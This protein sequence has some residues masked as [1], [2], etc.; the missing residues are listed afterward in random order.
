VSGPATNSAGTP[1]QGWKEFFQRTLDLPPPEHT[2]DFL[3]LITE[4]GS[5][6]D[7]GCG[8]GRFAVAFYRDR[9]D[10]TID[11]IDAHLDQAP[12]LTEDTAWL[13][14]RMQQKFKDFRAHEE[15]D[16]IWAWN[17]LFFTPPQHQQDIFH[18]LS[19]ALKPKGSLVF[20]FVEPCEG[21]GFPFHGRIRKDLEGML[22]NAVLK[23]EKIE[24]QLDMEFGAS[25]T[26]LPAFIIHARKA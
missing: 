4:N 1:D 24:H 15:Y 25:K 7:F 22:K 3:K 12:L 5:V 8:S 19:D 23:I 2:E 21:S 16:G 14:K 9:P 11:V 18:R 13:G 10:L 6:L 20:T 17:S 26:V